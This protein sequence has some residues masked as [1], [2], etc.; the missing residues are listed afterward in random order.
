MLCQYVL[1]S[2]SEIHFYWIQ[3]PSNIMYARLGQTQ[4]MICLQFPSDWQHMMLRNVK[5]DIN[6]CNWISIQGC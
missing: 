5:L 2:V 1:P 6:G 4:V 3:S